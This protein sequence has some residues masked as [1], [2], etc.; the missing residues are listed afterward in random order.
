[1]NIERRRKKIR[2]LRWSVKALFLILYVVPVTYFVGAPIDPSVSNSISVTS[3]FVGTLNTSF[4]RVPIT[5]SVCSAWIGYYGNA[6]PG[7]WFLCPLGGAQAFLSGRVDAFLV[8]PTLIAMFVFLIPIVLLG[9]VFCSWAC[10]VG[11]LVDSF[12][13][14]V[15]KFLPKIEARRNK[16]YVKNMQSAHSSLSNVVCPSCP[17]GKVV[18]NKNGIVAYGILG[19]ALVGSVALRF[20]VFCAVCPMGILTRGMLY[21][22]SVTYITKGISKELFPI[23]IEMWIIPV[24]AVLVSLR[25]RRFW[26]KKLCPVGW[27]L[28]GVGAL[29]PFI[30]PKVKQEKCIMKG[31][32]D[33]CKDYSIDYCGA[34]RL[35]DDRRCEKVCPAGINLVD[36]GSLSKCTKCMECYVVCDYNAVKVEMIAKPEIFR[37]RGFFRRLKNRWHKSQAPIEGRP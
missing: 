24:V 27:L 21:L 11:T 20:N 10:P 14:G 7:A 37:L 1:M 29:N 13:K 3:L 17:L 33:D 6:N 34:C 4:L 23:I 31:C 15:E 9:N 28:N 19:S 8:A 36:N 2:Y 30:K 32:P 5:Q 12:D 18:S 26:C 35:E 22:K 16:R 25:E